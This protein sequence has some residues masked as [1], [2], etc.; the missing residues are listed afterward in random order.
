MQAA[1]VVVRCPLTPH[2]ADPEEIIACAPH[3]VGW[4][5]PTWPANEPVAA[6]LQE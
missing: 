2:D 5:H 3:R 1:F 6:P 4:D